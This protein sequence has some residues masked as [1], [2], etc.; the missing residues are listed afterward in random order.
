MFHDWINIHFVDFF[1]LKSRLKNKYKLGLVDAVLQ[2]QVQVPTGLLLFTSTYL[3]RKSSVLPAVLQE[4]VE[5][6]SLKI[7]NLPFSILI[8]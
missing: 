5:L 2:Y 3:Q 1:Y 8:G 7:G 6:T 4:R